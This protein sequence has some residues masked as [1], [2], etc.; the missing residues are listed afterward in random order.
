MIIEELFSI[1]QCLG[2]R[3][4]FKSR[5]LDVLQR[6]LSL[7]RLLNM[8]NHSELD[9]VSAIFG[10]RRNILRPYRLSKSKYNGYAQF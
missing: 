3:T 8:H 5:S 2:F 9:R 7:Y 4:P 1:A 6:E 10:S